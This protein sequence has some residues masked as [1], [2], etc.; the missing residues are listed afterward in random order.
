MHLVLMNELLGV[1]D[2]LART[3]PLN[4]TD[5]KRHKKKGFQPLLNPFLL[6]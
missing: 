2:G 4:R 5:K 1:L 6:T 3:V